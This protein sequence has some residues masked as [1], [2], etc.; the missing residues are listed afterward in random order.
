MGD[1]LQSVLKAKILEIRPPVARRTLPL[2]AVGSGFLG[3]IHAVRLSAADHV[4]LKV[5][6]GAVKPWFRFTML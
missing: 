5:G 3:T 1:L 6:T 4:Y 2:G